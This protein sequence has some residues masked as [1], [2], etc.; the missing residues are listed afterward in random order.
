MRSRRVLKFS[1]QSP[2]YT[3]IELMVALAI[4]SLVFLLL[5]SGFQLGSKFS[6]VREERVT[7]SADVISVQELL[8]RLL[9]QARPITVNNDDAQKRDGILFVGNDNSMRFVA[10]LP[11]HLGVGGLYEVAIYLT[12]DEHSGRPGK[13]LMMS[14]RLFQGTRSSSPTLKRQTVLL[15]GVKEIRCSY[16][17][18]HIKKP[19]A[20]YNDWEGLWLLPEVVRIRLS[21][22]QNDLIWPEL[23]VAPAVNS[24]EAKKVDK[25]GLV[26]TE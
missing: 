1:A 6:L 21:F 8:R 14:W 19:R 16:F 2:G 10:P 9:S 22:S 11:R 18:F 17:G 3:L 25:I 7:D 24:L 26:E 5:T 12:D 4:L 13:R 20:W 23:I 15:S